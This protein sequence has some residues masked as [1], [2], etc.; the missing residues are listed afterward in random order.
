VNIGNM[1]EIA[2]EGERDIYFKEE[3]FDLIKDA[4]FDFVR[5]PVNWKAH[6]TRTGYDDG[7]RSYTIEPAF[8]VRVD[9]VIGWAL[10]RE[11]VII[12]ALY[13]Y[14]SFMSE[15]NGEQFWF[16]WEQIAE[17]YKDYPPQV[18]FELLNEPNDK[19]TAPLWNFYT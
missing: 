19:I 11:L 2:D 13:N 12:I 4:G 16:L 7:D 3:Y 18:L 17:H 1:F 10:S 9:E 8:F 14:D 6:T 15:P 5:L